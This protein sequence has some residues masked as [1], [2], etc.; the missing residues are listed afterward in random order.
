MSA[1]LRSKPVAE[2]TPLLRPWMIHLSPENL[3]V[4]RT[5]SPSGGD[6]ALALPP[7]RWRKTPPTALRPVSRMEAAA[8]GAGPLWRRSGAT[9]VQERFRSAS[10]LRWRSPR[11][12]PRP[13]S[14]Y[15]DQCVYR[16]SLNPT[17][18]V[19]KSAQDGA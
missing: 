13:E 14:R 12:V 18:V 3:A 1:P 19:M 8:D 9:I 6:A 7:V 2:E 16:K 11:K 15:R 10:T 5:P 4:V 17:I